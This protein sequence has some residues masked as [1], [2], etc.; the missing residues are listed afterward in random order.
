M[1]WCDPCAADPLTPEELRAARRVLAGDGA[2][3]AR[4][5]R[6]RLAG[7]ALTRL[8]VRY[9][10][11]HFPEDLV[12]QETSDRQNFQARYVLRH[13]F[14]GKLCVRGGPAVPAAAGRAAPAGGRDAGDLTGWELGTITKK[15]GD[16][17]PGKKTGG[18]AKPPEPWYKRL[19]Q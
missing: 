16:D 13:A 10:G 1:G 19:W 18:S 9:D 2:D 7:G 4:D 12:F 6:R 15:M 11:E 3:G 17:A 14:K 8:H 5:V